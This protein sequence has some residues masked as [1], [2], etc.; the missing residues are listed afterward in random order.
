[1]CGQS[2]KQNRPYLGQLQGQ[3]PQDGA[4]IDDNQEKADL[5]NGY[6]ASVFQN[7]ETEPIPNFDDRNFMQDLNTVI[8]SSDK[9]SKAIDRLK[10]SESQGPD[11]IHPMLLKECTKALLSPLKC[12]FEKS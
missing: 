7:E 1:M 12:I 11:N 3:E 4:A 6:F 8:I 10:S 9:I 2:S 5:L